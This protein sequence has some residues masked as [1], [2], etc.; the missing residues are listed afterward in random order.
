MSTYCTQAELRSGPNPRPEDE[1]HEAGLV[2]RSYEGDAAGRAGPLA[3]DDQFG[4][5]YARPMAHQD[6]CAGPIPIPFGVPVA[7]LASCSKT[8]R[9][10]LTQ[11]IHM[12]R[13][14]LSAFAA[15]EIRDIIEDLLEG[16]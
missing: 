11:T 6:H 7:A 2:L 5:T 15:E 12:Y 13:A 4:V 3:I 8:I 16:L 10:R 14:S 1:V 9:R